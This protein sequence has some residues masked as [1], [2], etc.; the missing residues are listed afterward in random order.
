MK[1]EGQVASTG[2]NGEE[3]KAPIGA[4]GQ[5]GEIILR[6]MDLTETPTEVVNRL[7]LDK[8]SRK[9]GIIENTTMNLWV[10]QNVRN[11]VIANL[12]LSEGSC[13]MELALPPVVTSTWSRASA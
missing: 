12:L 5:L 6:K 13:S 2:Q 4:N 8:D 7:R 10:P 9:G 11:F 3:K 1:W